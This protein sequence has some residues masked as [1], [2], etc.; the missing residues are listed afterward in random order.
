MVPEVFLGVGEGFE[1]LVFGWGH[2]D[3]GFADLGGEDG[4]FFLFFHATFLPF[5]GQLIADGDAAQALLDPFLRVAFLLVDLPHSLGGK[6]GVFDF[7]QTLVADLG[8]PEFEWLGF[9][10]RDGLDKAEESLCVGSADGAN[11]PIRSRHGYQGT[12]CHPVGIKGR[13]ALS[14][15]LDVV[16]NIGS[17]GEEFDDVVDRE[18][19]FF[20]GLVP[21][22]ADL[23]FFKE[24]DGAHDSGC[25]AWC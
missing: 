10:R 8:Q 5:V 14:Q 23:F 7:L 20:L 16:F 1:G 2:A 18:I 21:S 4:E 25:L 13:I 12:I 17:A 19:P 9:R 22:A 24:G 11:F 15:L 3:G 6:F